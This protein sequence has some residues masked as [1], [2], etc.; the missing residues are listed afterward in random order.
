MNNQL[1]QKI[2]GEFVKVY[3]LLQLAEMLDTPYQRL[4]Q[5]VK[6][7]KI[8]VVRAGIV[9]LATVEAVEGWKDSRKK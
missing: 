4:D 9:R 5:R 8:Q 3:T 6:S 2:N 1:Y 7:G